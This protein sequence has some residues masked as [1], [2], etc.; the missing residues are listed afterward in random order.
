MVGETTGSPLVTCVRR[1]RRPR[2]TVNSLA[3]ESLDSLGHDFVTQLGRLV[4]ASPD[5]LGLVDKA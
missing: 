1:G 3:L 5:L 2:R 4:L